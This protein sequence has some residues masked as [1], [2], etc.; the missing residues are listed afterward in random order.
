MHITEDPSNIA[1]ADQ[2]F[3]VFSKTP[4]WLIDPQKLEWLQ[5][6]DSIRED[7]KQEVPNL[8]RK[9]RLPPGLRVTTT[10]YYLGQALGAWKLFDQR[11]SSSNSRSGLA[12]RLRKAFETLGPTYIKLGQIISSGE[13]IFPPELVEQFKM[14]RDQ[15]RPE[16]FNL[17]RAT[18]ERELGNDL[19]SIFSEFDET[20]LAAASI[21][22]VHRG[23][24]RTGEE[25]V[26]KVQ[27]ST[28][29]QLVRED[30]AAM[31]W[32][33]PALVGR[34]PVTSL[35]NPPS[36]VQLFAETIVEEL[37]FRL[38]AANMLDI[39]RIL[40]DTNQTALVVPRPHPKYVTRKVLVMEKLSGFA[41]DNVEEMRNAGIDTSAVIRA[42]MIAFM[43][44]AMIYGIFHGDLHGGNL[45]VQSDGIVALLDYGIT[46]RLTEPKR[47][48]FLRLLMGATIN[49][50]RVQVAALRDL[51]ALPADADIEEVVQELGLEGPPVDPTKLTPEELTAQVREVTKA[52]LG[53]GAKMPKELM[54]FIKN[55]L[56]L[57]SSMPQ[58]A[59][60][61]DIFAEIT[62][63]AAYFASKHGERIANDVGIDPRQMPVDLQGVKG[64]LGLDSSVEQMTYRE[65]HERREVIRKRM[66]NRQRPKKRILPSLRGH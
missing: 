55:M 20:A 7:S 56:F 51:G 9:R 60:D 48:A 38:E 22:Q 49:D 42:C 37:D 23:R 66:L 28:I 30:L 54:L 52:L 50:V 8:L 59:P 25:V 34:I 18:I 6:I 45:L 43:E 1:P 29:D 19:E 24:L 32:F 65:L 58:Y 5:S 14:L 47:L 46:G 57:D 17:V 15:V 40:V 11:G 62:N 27:R 39:A 10:A 2:A 63:L 26:V 35:A 16:P 3:G 64:S 33:A 44:G 31:S 61:V 21:A 41:W 53:Y 12:R 36:L 13:G 4:P